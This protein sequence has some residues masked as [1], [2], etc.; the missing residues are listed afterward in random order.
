MLDQAN[1]MGATVLVVFA[2]KL[3]WV[4]GAHHAPVGPYAVGPLL[5]PWL[6]VMHARKLLW[7]QAP[8]EPEARAWGARGG[9]TAPTHRH[10]K[11]V[12][13]LH[14]PREWP[15]G[16]CGYFVECNLTRLCC[17]GV[18]S[19]LLMSCVAPKL[20]CDGSRACLKSLLIVKNSK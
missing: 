15:L 19:T 6:C 18:N 13:P 5:L 14:G 8:Q 20:L 1:A 9:A 17:V 3:W 12:G 10:C 2:N 7:G 16:V 4:G 11:P